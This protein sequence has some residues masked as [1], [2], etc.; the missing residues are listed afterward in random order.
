[1]E[2][3]SVVQCRLGSTRLPGKALMEIGGK[4]MVEWVLLAAPEPRVLAVPNEPDS[5]R[6]IYR[7]ADKYDIFMPDKHVQTNDVLGRFSACIDERFPRA[8]HIIRL[9]ADC[10]MLYC[11]DWK[12][13][14]PNSGVWTNRPWD[15]DG[16]D[17]EVIHASALNLA[18][19]YALDSYDREHV[20]PWIYR[21]LSVRRGSFMHRPPQP[22][23][24]SEKVS[25]D[26]MEDF[27][28]V[29]ALMEAML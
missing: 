5:L 9:T 13:K 11:L 16:Y 7:L 17:V 27:V 29:K 6:L 3:I 24:P 8:T 19:R 23:N 15:P 1:M 26:T 22:E 10:P 21:H 25:V 28:K 4:P 14:L 18:D 2:F 12:P 20:T